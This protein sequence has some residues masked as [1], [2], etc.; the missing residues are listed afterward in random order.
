[1]IDPFPPATKLAV[2][3]CDS[4]EPDGVKSRGAGWHERGYA[5]EE[6]RK[7]RLT[8][9]ARPLREADLVREQNPYSESL[10]RLYVVD[11]QS[12]RGLR[13]VPLPGEAAEALSRVDGLRLRSQ[14]ARRFGWEAVLGAVQ[15]TRGLVPLLIW[16]GVGDTLFLRVAAWGLRARLQRDGVTRPH[17]RQ[18]A[19]AL[20][21]YL[22]GTLDPRTLLTELML[23]R[24]GPRF[25]S[26]YWFFSML[27]Y[28]IRIVSR[29][30]AKNLSEHLLS[31]L[32]Y[33]DEA[34]QPA[35]MP[36]VVWLLRREVSSSQLCLL[37]ARRRGKLFLRDL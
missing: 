6:T 17:A 29:D 7:V 27:G 21:R 8:E 11:G 1:M 26:D 22:A 19:V 20:E 18:G 34:H 33:L 32:V 23:L 14:G 25:D 2:L 24:Q 28:V 13:T 31:W 37:L 30:K 35:L 15:S 9:T 36:A 5:T 16:A 4:S 10:E 3:Y 12:R